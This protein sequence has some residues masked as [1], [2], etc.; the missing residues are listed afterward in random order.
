MIDCSELLI[1]AILVNKQPHFAVFLE[2]NS[3]CPP[4]QPLEVRERL[5]E[6]AAVRQQH[7]EVDRRL[8]G[9]LRHKQCVLV[10]PGRPANLQ[11]ETESGLSV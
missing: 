1:V 3:C 4:W 11:R 9:R 7:I 8:A 2:S 10:I 5:I 6:G